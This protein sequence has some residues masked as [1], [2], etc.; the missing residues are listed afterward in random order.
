MGRTGLVGS[1]TLYTQPMANYAADFLL[2]A[3]DRAGLDIVYTGIWNEK[4]FNADYVK[5]LHKSLARRWASMRVGAHD[6]AHC[7]TNCPQN[8]YH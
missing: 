5:M 2:G 1:D 8:V 6:C 3:K 7:E 4:Q